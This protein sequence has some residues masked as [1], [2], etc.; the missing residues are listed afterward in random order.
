[1]ITGNIELL[2]NGFTGTTFKNISKEYL[3]N[4]YIPVPTLKIQKQ[5]ESEYEYLIY[6]KNKIKEWEK[7]GN[8]FNNKKII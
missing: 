4:L 5:I 3:K 8:E 2:N 6:S 1:M 7:K